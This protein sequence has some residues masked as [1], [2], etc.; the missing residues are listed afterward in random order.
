MLS[1]RK[2]SHQRKEKMSG[3]TP[4]VCSDK[5]KPKQII[6]IIEIIELTKRRRCPQ[7]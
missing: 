7:V 1:L 3:E 2:F 5:K 4:E 6:E